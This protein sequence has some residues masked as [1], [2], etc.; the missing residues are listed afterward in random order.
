MCDTVLESVSDMTYA[1]ISWTQ[2]VNLLCNGANSSRM[3]CGVFEDVAPL[4]KVPS[5][6]GYKMTEPH[7]V[8]KMPGLEARVAE[9]LSRFWEL[10]KAGSFGR[11]EVGNPVSSVSRCGSRNVRMLSMDSCG[12]VICGISCEEKDASS[13]GEERFLNLICKKEKKSDCLRG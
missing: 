5:G 10:F 6:R 2:K 4:T 12:S 7:R 13:W 1:L 8:K 3:S 9:I 11:E